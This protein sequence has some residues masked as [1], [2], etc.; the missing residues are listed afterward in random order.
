MNSPSLLLADEPTG[1]L[2][3]RTSIEIM[4]VMQA[5][6]EQ[7]LTIVLVTHEPDIAEHA[8]RRVVFRDGHLIQDELNP[9]K[10][11]LA[12]N[13]LPE[14]RERSF[15]RGSMTG[16]NFSI[17]ME[18]LWANK[19]RSLLTSLGIPSC[20]NCSHFSYCWRYWD[21]EYYDCL[22]NRTYT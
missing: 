7:G 5:L 8:K 2:D 22:R 15:R 21:Y 17:A 9:T 18:A 10:L 11:V 3:S 20:E 6:N 13:T 1:N 12:S 19:L 16:T 14:M 4:A